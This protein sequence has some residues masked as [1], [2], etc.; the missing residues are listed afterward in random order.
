VSR[1][2]AEL[3]ARMLRPHGTMQDR[4]LN[5]L[6]FL[7]RHGA[8]LLERLTA[9]LDPLRFEHVLVHLETETPT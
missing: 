5:P 6:P 7:V 4:V 3:V 2:R 8:D 1:R 9:R